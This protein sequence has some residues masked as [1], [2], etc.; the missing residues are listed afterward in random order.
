MSDEYDAPIS[1]GPAES[2]VDPV[3][4]PW[5]ATTEI[6]GSEPL[7]PDG[8]LLPLSPWDGVRHLVLLP[9]DGVVALA[10]SNDVAARIAELH[11]AQL[12]DAKRG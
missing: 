11:N 4:V 5:H 2:D 1:W 6:R 9:D 3:D 8:S 7:A 10:I 12:G